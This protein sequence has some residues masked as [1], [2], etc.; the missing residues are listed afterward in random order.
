MKTLILAAALSVFAY[1]TFAQCK[2]VKTEVD[3]FTKTEKRSA[4]LMVGSINL[5][6]G[7]TKWLFTFSQEAGKT[8]LKV[9]VA[10][11]GEFN[12]VFGE[13]TKFMLLLANDELVEFENR[14]PASPVTQAVT[15]S[16]RL[17]VFTT[18][19]LTLEPTK[20][21]LLQLAA[22]EVTDVRV[23]VPDQKIKSPKVSKKDG[24]KLSE[25]AGCLAE[26]AS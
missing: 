7:G 2:S 16:A 24:K 6:T 11:M 25:I 4:E 3:K 26:T 21:Q 15:T 1:G 12:Q 14:V 19:T 18:Y 13:Q 5:V 9:N 8:T 17:D 10:M 20:A 22:S 23:V